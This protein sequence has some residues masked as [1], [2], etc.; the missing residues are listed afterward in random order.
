MKYSDLSKKVSYLS[1]AFYNPF[2]DPIPTRF[3]KWLTSYNWSKRVLS[4]CLIKSNDAVNCK[5][6]LTLTLRWTK[7]SVSRSDLFNPKTDPICL[8]PDQCERRR[9]PAFLKKL[10]VT[11]T[12]LTH[13]RFRSQSVLASTHQFV[14]NNTDLSQ[15]LALMK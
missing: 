15:K 11:S 7:W 12:L 8:P 13:S 5:A 6:D 1:N 2:P 9:Q 4:S 3:Y 14:F 10:L